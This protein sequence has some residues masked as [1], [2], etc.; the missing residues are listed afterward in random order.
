M[1][2][3]EKIISEA[4]KYVMPAVEDY[5]AARCLLLNNIFVGLTIAHEAVEKLIKAILILE[6]IKFQKLHNLEKLA[7][8][9][10]KKNSEKYKFLSDQKDFIKRLDQ[11]Y[12]WRYYDGDIAKRSQSKSPEDLN[13]FDVLWI[14]LYEQYTEFIPK[15]FQYR[16]YLYAHLFDENLKECTNWGEIL[17][18][19]NIALQGKLDLW[20]AE[21]KKIFSKNTK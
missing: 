2:D 21:Y 9:L 4:N 20:E 12:G 5:L 15:E 14:A 11:H 7:D 16:T 10:P 8:L 18:E 19:N 17:K 6:N 1:D 3:Q 13:P